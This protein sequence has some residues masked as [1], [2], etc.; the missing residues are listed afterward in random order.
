MKGAGTQDD[1]PQQ[2]ALGAIYGER[3]PRCDR[4]LLQW[5]QQVWAVLVAD[6][7]AR[8]IPPAATVLDFGCGHGEFIN[9][10]RA[11]R[12]VAIDARA[13]VA[14]YLEPGVEFYV[15]EGFRLPARVRGGIDVVFCSNLLEHLPDRATVT[16]L[17]TEFRRALH[18]EGRLL[19]LG[20]NL[21]YTGLAY[22]DFFDHVLPFTHLS[23][24][25]ALA[26]AG[27]KTEVL[28]PRFLPFTTVGAPR[29]PLMLV[30]W[31]L[32]LPV[33]WRVLGAQYFCVMCPQ[34]PVQGWGG[35]TGPQ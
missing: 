26:S 19:V 16:A 35:S 10:V 9:A 27:F 18:P 25:E 4:A 1:D 22:W 28:I 17:L 13:E 8:W 2:A 21:R 7:F 32:R 12:R 6:F 23:L 20:P 24:V 31:Y 3:F 33:L 15:S 30:R 11:R 5:R 29:T 14:E 34:R